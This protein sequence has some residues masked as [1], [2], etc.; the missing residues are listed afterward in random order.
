VKKLISVIGGVV[1]GLAAGAVIVALAL[2]GVLPLPF[3]TQGHAHAAP[4]LQR[5]RVTVMYP[6]KERIVNL[7]DTGTVRYLK[8]Q[9]TL[10]FID[11]KEKEPP[12]G[13]AV[14][15]QQESF[16]KEM[17]AH[18]PIIEDRLT[19]V[20]SSKTSAELLSP[21]GKTRLKEEIMEKLN[22]AF[23]DAEKVVDVYFTSF[24]I[25]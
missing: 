21:A 15:H 11:R 3:N 18:L 7:V 8:A 5:P 24:I 20:L 10:E 1:G 6:T 4:E 17:S 14:K 12:K 25:Q 23:H 16:A 2:S 13:E 22:L 9:V 19:S